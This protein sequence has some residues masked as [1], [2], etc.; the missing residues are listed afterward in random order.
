M[1][2][3]NEYTEK[4]K[5]DAAIAVAKLRLANMAV[6]KVRTTANEILLQNRLQIYERLE[7]AN[8]KK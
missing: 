7:E 6:C 5:L 8:K 1:A 2:D 4:Q 3:K